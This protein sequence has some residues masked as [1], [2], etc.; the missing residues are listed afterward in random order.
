MMK[1]KKAT[2]GMFVTIGLSI[3]LFIG[4]IIAASYG[5]LWY[6]QVFE[7]KHK[8]IDREVWENTPSRVH[9]VTQEVSKRMVEY[10]RAED[11]IEKRAIC[12]SLRTAYS[13]VDPEVIDDYELRQFFKKCKYGG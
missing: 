12:S 13:N 6:R 4:L 1:N 10:N 5:G 7:P 2:M 9:G 11:E 3:V 8:I